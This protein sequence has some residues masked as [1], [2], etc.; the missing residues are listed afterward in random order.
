MKKLAW[1]IIGPGAIAGAFADDLSRVSD[2]SCFIKALFCH[3][4]ENAEAFAMRF[5][6][7]EVHTDL[8]QFIRESAIDAVYIATP[9]SSHYEYAAVCLK[10]RIPVLCEKPLTISYKQTK[11]LVQLSQQYQ[12]LLMEG[13]WSRFLPSIIRVLEII[14]SDVIGD[15]VSI[16][17]SMSY[18]APR[19]EGN[20]YYDPA[21]GG[22][23]LLDLGIYPLFLSLL[24]LPSL[25]L[26]TADARKSAKGIDE[27]CIAL[28]TNEW[29]QYALLESSI[30]IKTKN[31]AVISGYKGTVTIHEPW[32]EKPEGITVLLNNGEME[33]YPCLWP[34]SGFQYEIAAFIKSVENNRIFCEEMPHEVT[35][36][37]SYLLDQ[38]KA[39]V[40][41]VYPDEDRL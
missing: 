15:I 11:A 41:V 31:E 29:K 20:R 7:A 22:G 39:Q 9:H 33:K 1:G 10:N 27:H 38:I 36:Q 24:L 28:F 34:G 3:R 19:D 17:A 6:D 37:L 30:L 32:N 8:M 16:K 18:Q 35:L 5:P 26:I 12:T 21:L 4:K 25:Q 13:M 14:Q 23:S 40:G 2:R